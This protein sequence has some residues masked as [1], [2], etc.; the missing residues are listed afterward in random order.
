MSHIMT[1]PRPA[2]RAP[3]NVPVLERAGPVRV[4]AGGGED[5][6]LL[7]DPPPSRRRN[8][9][10]P[11]LLLG[12]GLVLTPLLFITPLLNRAAWF[13]T[14]LAHELGHSA[15]AWLF[16]CPS[17]PVIQ[18]DGHAFAVSEPQ[19]LLVALGVWACLALAAW[20]VRHHRCRCIFLVSATLAYPAFAFT[21]VRDLLH[22]LAGH[23]GE[24]TISGI[25]FA[26][27]LSRGFTR[28]RVEQGL[29]CL[30]AWYLL[31]ENILLCILLMVSPAGR[32]WYRGDEALGPANDYA[33]VADLLPW[34]SLEAVAAVMFA[35][36]LAVVPVILVVRKMSRFT[37]SWR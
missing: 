26:R 25:F 19:V 6:R 24:L 27:A 9:P 35:V 3:G 28:S 1:T 32:A 36:A 17:V 7:P 2:R 22:L 29:Y 37:R 15:V 33:R 30:L 10:K 14:S 5:R 20:Q 18:L 31:V 4:P 23:L 16:G 34:C 8:V 21:G 12:P 13:F 11:F